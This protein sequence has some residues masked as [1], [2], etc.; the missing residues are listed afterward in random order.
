MTKRDSAISGEHTRPACWRWRLAIA[1]FL[2]EFEQE[3]EQDYEQKDASASV[4]NIPDPTPLE[5][6]LAANTALARTR[7]KRFLAGSART[8]ASLA[9]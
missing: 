6:F 2:W 3:Y 4:V 5:Y 1:N 7:A 9:C 8:R